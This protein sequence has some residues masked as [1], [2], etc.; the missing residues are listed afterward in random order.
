M[1]SVRIN[2]VKHQ[3]QHIF[4]LN[5]LCLSMTSISWFTL[6]SR[7]RLHFFNKE[8]Q[9]KDISKMKKPQLQISKKGEMLATW[10]V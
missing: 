4:V 7:W 5:C 8:K 10:L 2:N 1:N 3:V 6:C 9:E